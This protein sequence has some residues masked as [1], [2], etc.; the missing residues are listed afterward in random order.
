VSDD[1]KS[2]GTEGPRQL[3]D[4][5]RQVQQRVL[6]DVLRGV[7]LAVATLVRCHGV[8]ASGREVFELVPIRVP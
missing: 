6:A 4:V 7:A 3:D 1:R 5:S 2:L 8:V